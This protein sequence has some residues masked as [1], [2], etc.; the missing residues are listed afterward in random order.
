MI[1]PILDVTPSAASRAIRPQ[2]RVIM[3]LPGDHRL[4]H[5]RQK[6]LGLG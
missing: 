6:L 1:P 2:Q 3:G 5:P 4:L